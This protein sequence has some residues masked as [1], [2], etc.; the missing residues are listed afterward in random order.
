VR[1]RRAVAEPARAARGR[2]GSRTFPADK[3][4]SAMESRRSVEIGFWPRGFRAR[5]GSSFRES[6]AKAPF[7]RRYRRL[8][9][10]ELSESRRVAQSMRWRGRFVTRPSTVI[11]R[12]DRTTA[13]TAKTAEVTIFI[14]G[15][16]RR[17]GFII[18]SLLPGRSRS[19]PVRV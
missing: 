3:Y 14:L 1:R 18:K 7:D 9:S 2:H 12:D 19:D 8:N 4:R 16:E 15:R 5:I 6:T 11:E 17:R 10:W 13:M